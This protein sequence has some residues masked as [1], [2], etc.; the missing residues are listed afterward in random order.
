MSFCASL[1]SAY[2]TMPARWQ[3]SC[4]V[5][6]SA[7]QWGLCQ[8]QQQALLVRVSLQPK[9]ENPWI[10]KSPDPTHIRLIGYSLNR[11]LGPVLRM[12]LPIAI[13]PPLPWAL[14][15]C[16]AQ[17]PQDTRSHCIHWLESAHRSKRQIQ[18]PNTSISAPSG[19]APS[20]SHS[21]H[22]TVGRHTSL[23]TS[24]QQENWS[25]LLQSSF[26]RQH[27]GKLWI[28]TTSV[29]IKNSRFGS[30]ATYSIPI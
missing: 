9:S 3:I 20:G 4:A 18:L 29:S 14:Q 13:W 17:Q 2:C 27:P 1:K 28:I 19:F 23:R 22:W 15:L 16:Y 7:L 30:D 25:I 8:P 21:N 5:L 10:S 24:C 26:P 11:K 6:H 12:D